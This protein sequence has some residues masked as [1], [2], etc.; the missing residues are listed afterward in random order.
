MYISVTNTC[1]VVSSTAESQNNPTFRGGTR[2]PG[3]GAEDEWREE[4]VHCS[5]TGGEET[6]RV[7][8]RHCMW[9]VWCV[10]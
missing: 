4:D 2:G 3:T 8:R 7:V 6:V 10:V 1:V 9:C 5:G